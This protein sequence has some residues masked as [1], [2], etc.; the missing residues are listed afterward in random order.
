M[1]LFKS[2]ALALALLTAVCASAQSDKP[3]KIGVQTWTLRN[4]DFNQVLEFAAKHKLKYLQL[5]GKHID[6]MKATPEEIKEKKAIFEKHG[7]VP[8]TFGVAATFPE[9]EQ[10]RKLFEF[11]KA[12]G[13]KLIIVEP[14][15]FKIL[16]HL[17]ALAKEYDVRVA[18]H[19][20]G[21]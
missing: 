14:N 9:K 11:A 17:E 8:Y 12:M 6:P 5:I 16:D 19:N 3:L 1:K 4:L 21:I 10:N 20:H 7:L 15:D 2:F 18:I 13:I